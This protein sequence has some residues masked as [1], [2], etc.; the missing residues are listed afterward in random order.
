MKVDLRSLKD[1]RELD[2]YNGQQITIVGH[3]KSGFEIKAIFPSRHARSELDTSNAV[4]LHFDPGSIGLLRLVPIT[5]LAEVDG[6]LDIRSHGHLGLYPVALRT[7]KFMWFVP[8]LY[9]V[10]IVVAIFGIGWILARRRKTSH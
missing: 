3:V 6:T 8:D 7:P 9:L 4:W 10:V 2:Q 1:I 5:G